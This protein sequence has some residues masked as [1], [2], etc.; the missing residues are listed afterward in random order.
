MP[1]LSLILLKETYAVCRLPGGASVAAPRPGAFSLLVQAV[2]E[3]TLVCPAA[4]APAEAEIDAGWRCF[5]IMQSFDFSVPGI[6]ASVLD[7]LA[8]ARIGIFATST[9]STDYVLVKEQDVERAVEALRA[10][11]HRIDV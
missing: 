2:E 9:F 6:L 4:Q 10:A 3:T 1:T 8:R 7:P 11:G 5:R